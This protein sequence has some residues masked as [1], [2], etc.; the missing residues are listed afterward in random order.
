MFN[1]KHFVVPL[2]YNN[3][4]WSVINTQPNVYMRGP[5]NAHG[6]SH[7]SVRLQNKTV[8]PRVL[9]SLSSPS[10]GVTLGSLGFSETESETRGQQ[11]PG[12]HRGGRWADSPA[13]PAGVTL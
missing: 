2:Y 5:R 7:M 13:S 4:E 10:E 12:Q 8:G 11:C 9:L 6:H 3:L 1:T